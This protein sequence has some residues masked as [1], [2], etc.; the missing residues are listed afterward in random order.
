MIVKISWIEG[1]STDKIKSNGYKI[2]E[3]YEAIEFI[4]HSVLSNRKLSA[5]YGVSITP[6]RNIKNAI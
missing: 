6:I 1:Y 3:Y 4:K 5:I 2:L